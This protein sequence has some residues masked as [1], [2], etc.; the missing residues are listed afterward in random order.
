[1]SKAIQS[2]I[3]DGI[4][5]MFDSGIYN[6]EQSAAEIYGGLNAYYDIERGVYPFVY[7]EITGYS[8]SLFAQLYKY[9]GNEVFLKRAQSS[10][11][12]LIDVMRYS[13]EDKNARGSFAWAYDFTEGKQL[14]AYSFDCGVCTK[15]FL[16]LHEVT[17]DDQYL[18]QTK[19]TLDWLTQV[20]QNEDGSLKASYNW[21]LKRSLSVPSIW[22]E[23]SGCLHAKMCIP[24]AFGSKTLNDPSLIKLA[25]VLLHEA[26][27]L[28]RRDGGFMVNNF[29]NRVNLHAHCYALEGIIY[30]HNSL[31]ERD[32]LLTSFIRGAEWLLNVEKDGKLPEWDT[33]RFLEAK[34]QT[35]YVAAQAIRIWLIAYKLTKDQRFLDGAN[36]SLSY[37]LSMQCDTA[38]NRA[39]GGFYE[40]YRIFDPL[41]FRINRINTWATIFAIQA[42]IMYQRF[43]TSEAAQLIYEII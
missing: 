16:D 24:L 22:Y 39:R 34:L 1:M 21:S 6:A 41:R 13:G 40:G 10:A 20:M 28:Q 7:T 15:A 43:Q 27:K 25:E 35:S 31:K 29:D 23:N 8:I 2:K 4:R 14:K 32:D 37:I 17:H 18:A 19:E 36:R 33:A 42:L 11:K 30:L 38:D 26:L 5:W 9:S 3:D 12:W